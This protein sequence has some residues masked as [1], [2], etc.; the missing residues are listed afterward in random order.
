MSLPN[1]YELDE[2]KRDGLRHLVGAT[3]RLLEAGPFRLTSNGAEGMGF[4]A[5]ISPPLR[6]E[7]VLFGQ[8]VWGSTRVFPTVHVDTI[9]H[10]VGEWVSEV[11]RLRS[12]TD[13]LESSGV[14]A[15]DLHVTDV[16]II[17]DVLTWK[18]RG[19]GTEVTFSTELGLRLGLSNGCSL[20]V[21]ARDSE[22]G[23]LQF[24]YTSNP[25]ETNWWFTESG[26]RQNWFLYD[27]SP[28]SLDVLQT[29]TRTQVALPNGS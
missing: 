3:V 6:D 1:R 10:Y 22:V 28:D 4:L 29:A 12:L 2:T 14:H 19:D 21:L 17:R 5:V 18:A 20:L 8:P 26:I 7:V 9:R 23:I 11:P 13:C 25:A 16:W 27:D 24:V 15:D